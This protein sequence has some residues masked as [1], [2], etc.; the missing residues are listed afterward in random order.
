MHRLLKV[1]KHRV[2]NEVTDGD[3]LSEIASE[4]G[5]SLDADEL[6]REHVV[7]VQEGITD[8]DFLKN[9]S[10]EYDCRFWVSED[11]LNMKA[12]FDSEE[13]IV[14]EWGKTLLEYSAKMDSEKLLTQVEVVGWDNMTGEG[15]SGLARG[16]SMTRKVGS[17][18]L[19]TVLVEEN[20]SSRPLVVRDEN[21]LDQLGAEEKALALLT[22]NSFEFMKASAVCEG[23]HRIRSGGVLR[24]KKPERGFPGHTGF[25]K[26]CTIFMLQ[27]VTVLTVNWRGIPAYER[28]Y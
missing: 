7:R 16:S 20:F 4:Y 23:D 17:G 19:G 3:I 15:F 25:G 12:E 22:E 1:K 8:F 2:F 9:L 28:L 27:Q 6:P 5:L 24:L 10:R 21:I 26:L 18:A 13:D 14:L 11:T